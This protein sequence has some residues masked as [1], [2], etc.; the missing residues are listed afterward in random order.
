MRW[1]RSRGPLYCSLQFLLWAVLAAIMVVALLNEV[2]APLV[3]WM[4]LLL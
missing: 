4:R 2:I 3:R 1:G